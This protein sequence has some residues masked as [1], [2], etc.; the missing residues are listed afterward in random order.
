M[1]V[2]KNIG[3]NVVDAAKH[4]VLDA[5]NTG[6]TVQL[7]FSGGKDSIVLASIVY[8]LILDGKINAKQLIV[9]FIDEEAMFDDIIK[10]V[11]LWRNRFLEVGAKFEWYCLQVKHFNCLNSMS[12]EETFICWDQNKK[13]AWVREMPPYAITDDDFLI[14]YKDN[15]QLFLER[16]CNAYDYISMRGVRVAESVQ[17]LKSI[18]KMKFDK[19]SLPI[20]DMQDSDVWLYI[21]KYGLEYPDIY[22]NLYR[23]GR[24]KRD[25]R[26]SQFFSI[27]TAKVLVNL[28]EMYPDLMERVSRREPNAYLCALYWDTEMFGRRSKKR[29]ENEASETEKDY[30]AIVLDFINNPEEYQHPELASKI[31]RLILYC[32]GLIKDNDW[33]KMYDCIIAGDPK[34]RTVRTI[35]ATITSR[36]KDL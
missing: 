3:I 32:E 13:D 28:N 16:K 35:S 20:Y 7:S 21:K 22:E 11:K 6:K 19:V 12:E 31:K 33:K 2:K 24:S 27:D 5:F 26:V 1:I 17:R 23:I 15:Y 18:S 30:K 14:P 29:K 25:L 8:N 4:R 10:I 34:L 9:I 36:R